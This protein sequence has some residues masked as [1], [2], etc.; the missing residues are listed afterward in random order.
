MEPWRARPVPFW[1]YG[2]APP[3]ETAPRFLVEAVP[4]RAFAIWRTYAWCIT[5]AFGSSPKMCLGSLT[6]PWLSPAESNSGAW[7]GSSS[8]SFS[9]RLVAAAFAFA[10]ALAVAA[11]V[12]L[13]AIAAVAFVV[14]FLAAIRPS[15]RL[16]CRRDP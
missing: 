6:W 1:R 3:P 11:G 8:F 5:G 2:F 13:A 15:S 14:V 16:A 12:A 4:W 10:V 7:R 9:R